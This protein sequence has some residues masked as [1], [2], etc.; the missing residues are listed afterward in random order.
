MRRQPRDASGQGTW[1]YPWVGAAFNL[2]KVKPDLLEDETRA[3]RFQCP[4]PGQTP[5]SPPQDK[6][7]CSRS[8]CATRLMRHALRLCAPMGAAA[9]ILSQRQSAHYRVQRRTAVHK[10]SGAELHWGLLHSSASF[11]LAAPRIFPILWKICRPLISEDMKNKIHVL[12]GAANQRTSPS[13]N[14]IAPKTLGLKTPWL[15]AF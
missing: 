6:I 10:A 12:G 5:R 13:S 15:H 7:H 9:S 8:A 11:R 1:W 4:P 14:Q 2:A 3:L